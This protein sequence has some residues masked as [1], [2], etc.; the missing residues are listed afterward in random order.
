MTDKPNDNHDEEADDIYRRATAIIDAEWRA[1]GVSDEELRRSRV[2]ARALASGSLGPAF[3]ARCEALRAEVRGRQAEGQEPPD[4][5]SLRKIVDVVADA[6]AGLEA[7]LTMIGEN[8]E[9]VAGALPSSLRHRLEAA[10]RADRKAALDI[11]AD[12]RAALE[13]AALALAELGCGTAVPALVARLQDRDVSVR[14]AAL[15]ALGGLGEP[16]AVGPVAGLLSDESPVV[17]HRAAISLGEIGHPMAIPTLERC[18]GD[19]QL[20]VQQAAAWA[21]SRIGTQSA[22][23]AVEGAGWDLESLRDAESL[24]EYSGPAA[25]RRPARDDLP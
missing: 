18:L 3:R 1:A 19:E 15:Q 24:E 20:F 12:V 4:H 25:A 17:R 5:E 8:D 16:E 10:K 2:A 11:A 14:L 21:L 23:R 13:A 7:V 6:H 9:A 22:Q